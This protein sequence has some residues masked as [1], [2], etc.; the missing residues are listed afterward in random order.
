MLSESH[1]ACVITAYPCV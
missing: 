1:A